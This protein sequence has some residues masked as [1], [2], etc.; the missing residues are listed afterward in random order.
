MSQSLER[1]V[2]DALAERRR[3]LLVRQAATH[4]ALAILRSEPYWDEHGDDAAAAQDLRARCESGARQLA[5]VSEALRRLD[6]RADPV[7]RGGS[8]PSAANGAPGYC[9]S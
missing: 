2:R 9:H 8:A 1:Y 6:E 3:G 5:R 4:A 7:E